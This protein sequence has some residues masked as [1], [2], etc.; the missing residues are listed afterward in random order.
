M[1]TP[2]FCLSYNST[3]TARIHSPLG[4]SPDARLCVPSS[5]KSRGAASLDASTASETLLHWH[6]RSRGH[7]AVVAEQ[8]LD[9]GLTPPELLED[10][11][12]RRAPAKRQ[13]CVRKL[14]TGG[15]DCRLVV[16]AR[17]FEGS[18]GVR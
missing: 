1:K 16:Q 6:S 8:S 15:G 12:R 14:G 9:V 17:L 10:L 13:H 2:P 5:A 7:E 3:C 11:Q 4:L 18:E